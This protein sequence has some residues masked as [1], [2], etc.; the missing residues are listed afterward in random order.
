MIAPSR[1][2]SAGHSALRDRE[3][4]PSVKHN[5]PDSVKRFSA[6]GKILLLAEA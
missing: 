3:Q 4:Q 1:S 6:G 2:V 5:K